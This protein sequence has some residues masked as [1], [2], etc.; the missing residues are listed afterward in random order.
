MNTTWG[1]HGDGMV[2]PW[3]GRGHAMNTRWSCHGHVVV[4]P[5]IHRERNIDTPLTYMPWIHH[6]HA[7]N[8]SHEHTAMVMPWPCH[9][10]AMV[11]PWSCHK[12]TIVMLL[13]RWRGHGM[14]H[15]TS[16]VRLWYGWHVLWLNMIGH[17]HASAMN[18]P[19]RMNHGTPYCIH[20]MSIALRQCHGTCQALSNQVMPGIAD[21]RGGRVGHGVWIWVPLV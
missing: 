2:R 14:S 1:W 15:G 17:C 21:V 19:W 10:D 20:S 12:H 18:I 4:I 8:T 11:M 6:G 5:L 16:M 9:G 13:R 3:A 7:M